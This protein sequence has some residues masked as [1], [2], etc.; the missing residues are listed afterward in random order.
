MKTVHLRG[1]AL[2]ILTGLL[3]LALR[4]QAQESDF[5]PLFNGKDFAGWKFIIE[6]KEA[7]PG[8]T[9]KVKDGIVVVSGSPN[10]YMQTDKSFK[11]Y[12]LP[13][14][15]QYPKKSGNSGL[16][17]HIQ[18]PPPKGHW[19]K[20]VE[21]QGMHVDHGHIFAII[22]AKGDFKTDKDAQKKA[23]KGVGE[24]KSHV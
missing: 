11:N 12:V 22:G 5:R 7:P 24:W 2:A 19:P 13:F 20:S 8:Q 18:G 4:A 15:W 1:M 6:G 21:V 9:F 14:D 16:L 10:G 3:V 17:V 23:I